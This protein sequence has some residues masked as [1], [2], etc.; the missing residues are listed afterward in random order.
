MASCAKSHV[1]IESSNP[2]E[3]TIGE[4]AMLAAYYSKYRL[5]GTVPVDY[6]QVS[7]IRKPNGAKPGFVVYEGQQNTYITPDP[8]KVEALRNNKP[9]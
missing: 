7:K 5:S 3:E 9:K 4:G 2:A 6:V 1:I 8:L